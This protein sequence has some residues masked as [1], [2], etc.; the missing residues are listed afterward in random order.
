MI[1][2]ICVGPCSGQTH[3]HTF[4]PLILKTSLHGRCSQPHWIGE[5]I[6]K[7]LFTR[8]IQFANEGFLPGPLQCVAVCGVI[9][10]KLFVQIYGTHVQFCCM[11]RLCSSEARAFRVPITWIT[12]IVPLFTNLSSSPLSPSHPSKFPWFHSV[13]PREHIF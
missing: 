11:H 9:F 4:S 1:T 12:Y 7:L 3:S 5:G 8:V 13:C 6:E 2:S 10:K